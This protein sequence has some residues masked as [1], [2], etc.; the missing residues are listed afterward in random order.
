[1]PHDVFHGMGIGNTPVHIDRAQVSPVRPGL[2]G[3]LDCELGKVRPRRE[4]DDGRYAHRKPD[5][6]NWAKREQ[7]SASKA[8]DHPTPACPPHRLTWIPVLDEV[9][10]SPNAL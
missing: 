1:E 6:P 5:R 9:I 4:C 8:N 2:S 10:V 7:Q 3:S